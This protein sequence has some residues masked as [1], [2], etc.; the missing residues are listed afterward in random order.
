MSSFSCGDR[1]IV[2]MCAR[3]Q[4]ENLDLR[5]RVG[6]DQLLSWS[7]LKSLDYTTKVR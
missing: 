7:D 1:P 2:H 5:A 6:A 3:V 4:K